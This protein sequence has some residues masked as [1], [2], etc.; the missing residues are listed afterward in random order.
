MGFPLPTPNLSKVLSE[1]E[2]LQEALNLLETIY[3]EVG[4]YRDGEIQE[5]TWYKV[6]DFFG[7]DDS[8]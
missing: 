7:F 1:I 3:L 8:E 6:Q 5:K 4:P 2:K